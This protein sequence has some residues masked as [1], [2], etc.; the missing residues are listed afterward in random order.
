MTDTTSIERLQRRRPGSGDRSGGSTPHYGPG[1][2]HTRRAVWLCQIEKVSPTDL[3][4]AAT[5]CVWLA[6]GLA[7]MALTPFNRAAQALLAAGVLLC[8]SW[9]SDLAAVSPVLTDREFALARTLAEMAFLGLLTAVVATLV[10]YPDGSPDRRGHL[11]VPAAMAVATLFAPLAQLIG[12]ETVDHGNEPATART[13]PYAHPALTP[14][15]TAG[16]LLAATEPLW[17][18]LGVAM[19]LL[20]Y[21]AGDR[22]RRA[23]LR[24]PLCSMALLTV[25]LLLIVVSEIAR[26]PSPLRGVWPPLFLAA[27]SLWPAV[28]LTGI[29]HRSRS[30]ERHLAE[31]RTRLVE[32]EDAARTRLERDL[33]DGVQQQLVGLL[34]LAELARRQVKRDRAAVEQ[35][36]TE[37]HDRIEEA[38]T[39]LRHVVSGIRPPVL[40]DSGLAAALESRLAAVP[41][42]HLELTPLRGR[43]WPP[44]VEAAAYFVACEA[45]T[46]ALKHAPGTTVWLTGHADDHG[47]EL[48]VKDNG[49]GFGSTSER[50]GRGLAGMRDRVETLNGCF[51]ITTRGDGTCV[52]SRFPCVPEAVR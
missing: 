43:R 34:M 9:L 47:L 49:P 8:L 41:T 33:H 16:E 36:L 7:A 12:S 29:T 22:I 50:S 51:E 46:N 28:L 30:L 3:M 6:C 45:V 4:L 48:V 2:G 24:W 38:V 40:A 52:R 1:S 21:R 39:D 18:V 15:G 11:T 35:T 20:R 19:L 25:L 10:V 14:L 26:F 17:I 44:S 27:L 32:A 5:A 13:N 42:V 37:I 23:Q 31:S